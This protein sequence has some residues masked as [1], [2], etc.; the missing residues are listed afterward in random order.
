[1]LQQIYE[2]T[3]EMDADSV[4][5][6]F[7]KHSNLFGIVEYTYPMIPMYDPSDAM[8]QQTVQDSPTDDYLWSLLKIDADKAWNITKG[9]PTLVVAVVDNG[10]DIHHP[11]LVSKIFPPYDFYTNNTLTTSSDSHG[12][13]VASILAS[14]TV[15][16]GET[17]M[18]DMASIGYK[19]VQIPLWMPMIIR[20]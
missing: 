6:V 5:A 18:G 14:E 3:S 7:L 12:T 8:W 16:Y 13:I 9:D 17:A 15:D 19:T 10:F 20:G 11:D 4:M 1:M 2:F